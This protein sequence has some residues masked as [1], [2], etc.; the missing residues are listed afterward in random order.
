M[1]L[2]N[3]Q[4]SSTTV[5][6]EVGHHELIIRDRYEIASISNDILIG[7]IFLVGSFLFFSEA[8]MTFATWLFVMGSALMLVR[9]VI[10]LARRTH[11][12]KI[13]PGSDAAT[14]RDF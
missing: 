9:P 13:N 5:K 11:L 6:V 3:T 8:T 12:K 4:T 14:S 10:R 7:V 1:G 2:M